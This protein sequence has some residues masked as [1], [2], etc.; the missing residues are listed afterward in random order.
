[1]AK[2]NIYVDL[3]K[4]ELGKNDANF[5]VF[6]DE[7]KLGQITISKGGVEYYPANAKKPII[8]S[9]SDFDKMVKDWNEG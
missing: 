8:I 2:H 7:A 9:W 3:P 6:K 1:M 4:W 5:H